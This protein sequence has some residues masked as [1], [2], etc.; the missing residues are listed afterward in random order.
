MKF[1]IGSNF[2]ASKLRP[3]TLSVMTAMTIA[4]AS[5]GA[6]AGW[7]SSV[8]ETIEEIA[9][10]V[11]DTTVETTETIVDAIVSPFTSAETALD[12]VVDTIDIT[13][14]T[15]VDELCIVADASDSDGDSASETLIESCDI[16]LTSIAETWETTEEDMY[17]L[18]LDVADTL[19]SIEQ[20]AWESYASEF[21]SVF[22]Q[23]IDYFIENTYSSLNDVADTA[24]STM[25]EAAEVF[26]DV[27]FDADDITAQSAVWL[28][29]SSGISYGNASLDLYVNGV[30]SDTFKVDGTNYVSFTGTIIPK[31]TIAASGFYSPQVH[32]YVVY[33]NPVLKIEDNEITGLL[34]DSDYDGSIT[35]TVGVRP[36][37]VTSKLSDILPDSIG[38]SSVLAEA[39]QL[40]ADIGTTEISMPI[41]DQGG[42]TAYASLTISGGIDADVSITSGWA[43]KIRERVSW[44][45]DI[46]IE[47]PSELQISDSSV[48][49]SLVSTEES[50]SLET[51]YNL[52]ASSIT[53]SSAT[54]S[55]EDSS[56]SISHFNVR[57]LASGDSTWT[58][59]KVAS[60][61]LEVTLDDLQESTTYDWQVRSICDDD[62]GTNY[63]DSASYF[64]TTSTSSQDETC[65]PEVPYGLTAYN[66]TDTNV[67]VGWTD[68][69]SENISHYNVRYRKENTTTWTKVKVDASKRTN[70]LSD[71]DADT[72]YEWQI[73]SI[74]EDSTGTNYL[75][76]Q[77]YFATEE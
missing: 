3:L 21:T 24:V 43:I 55:W 63:Y 56:T 10:T 5:P 17:E 61:T 45:D 51:P 68:D 31:F 8:T 7:W 15:I 62:T 38:A 48:F 28:T 76:T 29:F 4:I 11:V 52:Q 65:T 47:V 46:G 64:E 50:C 41:T 13:M 27:G 53:E 36:L 44:T 14:D 49:A 26:S 2:K 66:V 75:D 18:A 39:V 19:T 1:P 59:V 37:L 34:V 33:N 9:E 40:T 23:M 77:A 6:Y 20:D 67:T 58:K 73:R 30:A 25:T 72:S 35:L 32:A 70:D 54:L 60:D 16:D 22:D 71:L 74:C 57:Y 12:T 42:E 69:D